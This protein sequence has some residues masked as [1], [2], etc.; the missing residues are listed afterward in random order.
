MWATSSP[1]PALQTRSAN[2]YAIVPSNSRQSLLS[3]LLQLLIRS[4]THTDLANRVRGL[5]IV[6]QDADIILPEKELIDQQKTELNEIVQGCHNLLEELNITLGR[7]QELDPGAKTSNGRHRR[8]WKRLNWDQKVIDGFR[9][10]ISSNI[11]LL[12]TFLELIS[13]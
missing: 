1:W 6:L 2:D 7:Y 8:V 3:E 5:S 4:K 10:R 13:R 9:G 11:L 12:N